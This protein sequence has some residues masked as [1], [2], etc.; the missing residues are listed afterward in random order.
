RVSD[1]V[2]KV[3]TDRA[4]ELE[5]VVL[6][7]EEQ[8]RILSHKIGQGILKVEVK[9]QEDPIAHTYALDLLGDYQLSNVKG[10]LTAL[11]I[12]K[13]SGFILPQAAIE[14]GLTTVCS[15]TGLKGRW[16]KIGT[17]PLIICDTAHNQAGL[18]LS[19]GQFRQIPAPKH[20]FVLGFV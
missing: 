7:G 1:Q 18:A 8:I 19:V 14:T 2:Y 3:F 5:T 17:H 10:V 16:Q 6:V 9:D 4:A 11:R 13:Q 15:T 20:R 12:L